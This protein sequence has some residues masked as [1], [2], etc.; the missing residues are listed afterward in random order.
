LPG[1]GYSWWGQCELPHNTLNLHT[2]LPPL[3]FSLLFK[4]LRRWP[5]TVRSVWATAQH[6]HPAPP[7]RCCFLLLHCDC[8]LFRRW[9]RTGRSV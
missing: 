1:T 5:H 3:L 2:A 8:L 7:H 4:T 9:P 6:F